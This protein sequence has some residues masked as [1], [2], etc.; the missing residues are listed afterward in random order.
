MAVA[1]SAFFDDNVH[2]EAQYKGTALGLSEQLYTARGSQSTAIKQRWY[3][4]S[5]VDPY[6]LTDTQL[7]LWPRPN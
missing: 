4:M 6:N 1:P 7:L 5:K 3:K 2:P